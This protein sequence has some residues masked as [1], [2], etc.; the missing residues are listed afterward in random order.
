VSPPL[1]VHLASA[2]SRRT[3]WL[4]SFFETHYEEGIVEFS[5]APLLTEEEPVESGISVKAQVE[6]TLA[7][8]VEA[9]KI[10]F[11][12]ASLA[13]RETPEF[14]LV[15]D[16]LV[17]DPDDS[18]ISLGKPS[19]RASAGTM[20]L[21]LQGR[22]HLVWSGS[23]LLQ[24]VD[25]ASESASDD[26]ADSAIE[27]RPTWRVE[28]MVEVATVEINQLSAAELAALLDSDSWVGK[29]GAYD[30][31][32]AMG[33]H[34]RVVAGDEVC[35]LGLAPSVIAILDEAFDGKV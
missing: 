30:I 20:L 5:A 14:I 33:E 6:Q 10:E 19:D 32:G 2:S 26:E 27:P 35:V 22:R 16:T 12:L 29:A 4:K 24:L 23:A 7:A 31:A 1:K 34:G 21:R 18:L 11:T 13:G 9:A 25:A 28:S 17:E 3:A 15:A 8:K